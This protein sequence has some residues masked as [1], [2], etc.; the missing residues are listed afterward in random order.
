MLDILIYSILFII[1]ILILIVL[2]FIYLVR[3]KIEDNLKNNTFLDLQNKLLES[4]SLLKQE[5]I[6][7]LQTTIDKQEKFIESTSKIEE[8]ARN[9]E[10]STIEIKTFKEI[11]A[12]PK[13]R[14]FLGEIMLEEIIKNLPSSYY[15]KQYPFGFDR[16]DYVLKL[17][18]TLI[19]IDAKFP[20]QNFNKLFEIEEKDKVGLKKE[21][22]KN[23][24]NKIDDIARKYILPSKG[25]IEFALMYLANEGIYYELL[26]DKDYQEV[27][28]YA[29]EK[30]VFITSP[31]SFEIICSSL[32]LIIRKQE[33]GKNIQQIL[34][35]LHQLEKDL[36]EL[37]SKFET[38]YN[39]LNNSFRNLQEL[40]RILNRFIV[41]FKALIKSEQKLEEKIKERS[42]I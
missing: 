17:N 19:P 35:N 10:S 37:E 24:K 38:S 28:D 22:A 42:L 11:L 32:L 40:S 30:S 16:V 3:I 5:A 23:L 13:N 14:G 29:R 20:I 2:Y 31:K 25:T 18:D 41:N 15:E 6:S 8:L 4:F 39:Q 1:F 27:W 9:L 7:H 36:L 26:T 12:G 34:A 33:L 21:L